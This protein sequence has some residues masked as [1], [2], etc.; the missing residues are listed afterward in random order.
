M[1][2][3]QTLSDKQNANFARQEIFVHL[4]L[5]ESSLVKMGR[6]VGV[7]HLSALSVHQGTAVLIQVLILFS[8]QVVHM[9]RQGAKHVCHVLRVLSV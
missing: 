9:R 3:T 5:K 1:G 8:V 2:H 6:T 4:L 7:D